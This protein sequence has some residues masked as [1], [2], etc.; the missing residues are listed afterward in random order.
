MFV[1]TVS[2]ARALS[3]KSYLKLSNYTIK[4]IPRNNK[5]GEEQGC[6]AIVPQGKLQKLGL[7]LSSVTFQWQKTLGVGRERQHSNVFH[8]ASQ[9]QNKSCHRSMV[10]SLVGK[11]EVSVTTYSYVP[12]KEE[13]A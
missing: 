13:K 1:R 6:V 4:I 9:S 5:H 12:L 10:P 3:G 2:G 8:V 7:G 11:V